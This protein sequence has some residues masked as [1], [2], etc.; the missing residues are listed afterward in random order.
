MPDPD[1]QAMLRQWGAVPAG[2]ESLDD[3]FTASQPAS[4]SEQL[5][6]WLSGTLNSA[7]LSAGPAIG[8]ASNV[9]IDWAQQQLGPGA[10]SDFLQRSQRDT[11]LPADELEG[12]GYDAYRG[13]TQARLGELQE[14]APTA[15]G[16]G[17]LTGALYSGALAPVSRAGGLSGLARNA[18]VDAGM[19]GI[20]AYNRT[21]G[22][23][24]QAAKGALTGAG[25]SAGVGGGMAAGGVAARAVGRGARAVGG[26]IRGAAP[27]ARQ[28]A[29]LLD[30]G[31]DISRRTDPQQ[32]MAPVH[33]GID[34]FFDDLQDPVALGE[35]ANEANA[36]AAGMRLQTHRR[37]VSPLPGPIEDFEPRSVT[38]MEHLPYTGPQAF[39]PEVFRAMD[40]PQDAATYARRN[41]ESIGQ[42]A[43]REAFDLGDGYILKIAKNS[44]GLKQNVRETSFFRNIPDELTDRVPK[45][46]EADPDGKW[47]VAERVDPYVPPGQP[48]GPTREQAD[49]MRKESYAVGP[50]A[51]S[52]P[53]VSLEGM[54]TQTREDFERLRPLIEKTS[55]GDIGAHNLGRNAQGDV[56]MLDTGLHAPEM[57]PDARRELPF[58]RQTEV[59]DMPQVRRG[60]GGVQGF[61]ADIERLGIAQQ[62]NLGR[63]K[64]RAAEIM[65]ISGRQRGEII[66]RVTEAQP[67]DASRLAADL[68]ARAQ[69]LTRIP[70]NRSLAGRLRIAAR[71]VA[72]RDADDPLTARQ[73]W[74]GIRGN[75]DRVNRNTPA[76][77]L[78]Y[79]RELEKVWDGA[80]DRHVWSVGGDALFEQWKRAGRDYQVSKI[81]EGMAGDM[82]E[83]GM[84]NRTIS[85]TDIIATVGGMAAGGPLGMATGAAAMAANKLVRMK[86]KPWVAEALRYLRDRAA[87]GDPLGSQTVEGARQAAQGLAGQIGRIPAMTAG[88]MSTGAGALR[89]AGRAADVVGGGLQMGGTAAQVGGAAAQDVAPYAARAVARTQAAPDEPSDREVVDDYMRKK[90]E[91]QKVSAQVDRVRRAAVAQQLPA[92][93]DELRRMI[94]A[95]ED[96][97][98]IAATVQQLQ[99]TNPAFGRWLRKQ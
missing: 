5:E 23:I 94:E 1:V 54:T 85:L 93:T 68:N 65:E 13:A 19:S 42:G 76:A 52:K 88:A 8:G 74:E 28:G 6:S 95:G 59:P 86:E 63:T 30:L 75:R 47:L 33:R 77:K 14:R 56:V 20:D 83:R 69:E 53:G 18:V 49:L 96:E 4:V 39:D 21:G 15:Y 11:G 71:E 9:A 50:H 40:D 82:I 45:I 72:G 2:G 22:D 80:L 17:E 16:M 98:Q 91:S 55:L 43:G 34:E 24:G 84:T 26:A 27:A 78:Q 61:G 44:D 7:M 29:E 48:A 46:L 12:K 67:L 99:W 3:Y 51:T 62:P 87:A 36:A 70:G 10:V 97:Q 66:D 79:F 58:P 81:A 25:F 90:V 35:R 41:L 57:I 92:G 38:Q 64:A 37:K 32:A 89:G 31:A 73:L 60:E